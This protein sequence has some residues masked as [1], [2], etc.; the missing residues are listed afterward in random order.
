MPIFKHESRFCLWGALEHRSSIIG[1]L[2]HT[3]FDLNIHQRIVIIWHY[4]ILYFLFFFF[5]FSSLGHFYI[6]GRFILQF[7]VEINFWTKY[8]TILYYLPLSCPQY[9]FLLRQAACTDEN[10]QAPFL[11]S[12][13]SIIIVISRQCEENTNT[14]DLFCIFIVFFLEDF[15]QSRRP[16][17]CLLFKNFVSY[18]VYYKV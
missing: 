8:Y 17:F 9:Y 2:I 18:K 15:W 7:E 11:F 12:I 1:K 5:A 6:L 13:A 14:K 3:K 16:V 10:T 4:F